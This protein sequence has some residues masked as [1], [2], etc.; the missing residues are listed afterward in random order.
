MVM[1]IKQLFTEDTLSVRWRG[2]GGK[3]VSAQRDHVH[4][5]FNSISDKLFL[6]SKILECISEHY[7]G[8]PLLLE[9][10]SDLNWLDINLCNICALNTI[11]NHGN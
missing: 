5:D 4:N 1:F 11:L 6:F 9:L 8:M 2:N 7:F 10:S 3:S